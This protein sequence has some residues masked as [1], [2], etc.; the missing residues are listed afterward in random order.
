MIRSS[1]FALA[2]L[3]L[4]VPAQAGNPFVTM[5]IEYGGDTLAEDNALYSSKLKAGGF[6]Y[7]ALGYRIPLMTPLSLSSSIGF[8]NDSLLVSNGEADFIRFPLELIL[9]AKVSPRLSIGG[10]LSY[11]MAPSYRDNFPQPNQPTQS[12]FDK[13]I[14]DFDNALGVV[15]QT[16][17]RLARQGD[18]TETPDGVE[19]ISTGG[20]DIGA[21]YTFID[22][23]SPDLISTI[24]GD[25]L[26]LFFN[27]NW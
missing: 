9:Q 25:S 17:Y 22:Y 14:I 27:F 2:C 26:G 15:L 5:A 24:N 1:L 7:L 18:R 19:Q 21:R 6:V 8:K 16:T 20:F 3:L 10:G 4:T 11:H 23:E 13:F 12:N